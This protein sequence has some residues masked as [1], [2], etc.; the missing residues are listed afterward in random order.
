[1]EPELIAIAAA[2]GTAMAAAMGTDVWN[3]AKAGVARLFG[4]GD[5]RRVEDA[6]GRLERSVGEREGL[7]GT[8]RDRARTIQEAV[9]R[10]RL[11]DLLAERPEDAGELKTLIDGIRAAS[12]APSVSARDNVF[13][14]N[15][16]TARRDFNQYIVSNPFVPG[17]AP[18]V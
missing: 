14:D 7:S 9:W 13:T 18:P 17:S 1:M 12:A 4:R 6:E 16:F 11:E 3:T 8:D 10:T 5:P 15:V 2:G